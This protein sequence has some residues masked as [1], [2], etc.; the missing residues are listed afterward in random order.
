MPMI[1]PANSPRHAHV[2]EMTWKVSLDYFK[3]PIL[4]S[5]VRQLTSPMSVRG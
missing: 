5:L 4:L 3:N 2:A 1:T